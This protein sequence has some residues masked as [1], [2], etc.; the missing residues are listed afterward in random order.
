MNRKA[1]EL[2]LSQT[3]FLN[4]TG[5]DM[6]EHLAGSYGS[7]KDVADL[8]SYIFRNYPSITEI[9]QYDSVNVNSRNFS[10]TNKLVNKLSRL[11]SGKTG[12]S[13]LAGGNLAVITDIG[14]NRPVAI[15]VLGSS[16]EGRFDDV[17]KLHQIGRAS[18]RERV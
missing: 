2:N 7:A 14:F 3:Y 8:I 18:C 11:L 17:E 4:P 5:L 6:S 13:D 1:Q 10:N 9:T 15:V 12:F 16:R